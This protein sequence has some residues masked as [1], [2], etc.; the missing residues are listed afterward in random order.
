MIQFRNRLAHGFNQ[1]KEMA[2]KDDES[3][4]VLQSIFRDGGWRYEL[5]HVRR[6]KNVLKAKTSWC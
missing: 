4:G 3:P 5:W 6:N 1:S 2:A